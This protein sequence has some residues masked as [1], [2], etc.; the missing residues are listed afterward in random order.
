MPKTAIY[1][2]YGLLQGTVKGV[3]RDALR[4]AP[5]DNQDED[6]GKPL[7]SSEANHNAGN[8]NQASAYVARVSLAQTDVDTEQGRL[9]LEPGMSVT[10]EIKTG[11]RRVI[12]YILSPLMRYRHEG[13]RER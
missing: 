10:A 9:P 4:T 2:R 6:Q 5:R 12:S 7:H 11:Q 8:G 1:T 3:S 13:L